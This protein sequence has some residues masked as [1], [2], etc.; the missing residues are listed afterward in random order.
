MGKDLR[1]KEL[2]KGISQEKS[3]LYVARY[4]DRFGKRQSKR[5]KKCQEA[6][7]WLANSTF[8]DKS[9]NPLFP[10]NMTSLMK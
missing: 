7:Q 6:R 10:Q 8:L 9:S 2:G 1:R 4:V 3:G 5:F